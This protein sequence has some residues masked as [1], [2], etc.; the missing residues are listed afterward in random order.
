MV[1]V[2]LQREAASLGDR[3]PTFEASCWSRSRGSKWSLSVLDIKPLQMRPPS[4]PE[5]SGTNR[6]AMRQHKPENRRPQMHYCQSQITREFRGRVQIFAIYKSRLCI[7]FRSFPD[8]P[9]I[10]RGLCSLN[11]S[12]FPS[13]VFH[14]LRDIIVCLLTGLISM[15]K[16]MYKTYTNQNTFS[17]KHDSSINTPAC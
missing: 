16:T 11:V 10:A 14:T 15:G 3:L 4:Y 2:L 7:L 12:C 5:M 8:Y 17:R 1:S 6:S 9:L 13:V